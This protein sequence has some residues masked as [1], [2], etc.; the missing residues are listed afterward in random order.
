MNWR[1]EL[2]TIL[3]SD[4]KNP[5][6]FRMLKS[7]I[8]VYGAGS[9]GN[10]ALDFMRTINIK[11]KYIVDKIFQGELH[12]IKVIKP[13]EI[14]KSD[15]DELTFIICIATVS[16]NPIFNYLKTMG[17]KDVRHFYDYSEIMFPG[18]MPN[19]WVAQKIKKEDIDGINQTFKALEHDKC[20]IAHYLQF[21]WW[22][23]KRKE[24]INTDYPV[25]S[26]KKFFNAPHFPK[27]NSQ[28][29]FVDAGVHFGQTIMSFVK[30]TD[31]QF[32]YICGFEPDL[33]NQRI[34]KKNISSDIMEKTTLFDEAL[35]NEVQDLKFEDGLGFASK[36]SKKGKKTV[37][38]TALDLMSQIEPTII[39]LHIEGGELKALQGAK[40]KIKKYRPI[41]MIMAD[42]SIDGLYKITQA[43]QEQKDYILYFNLHD[44][45]GNSA[46]IYGYPKERLRK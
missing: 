6:P 20:S 31:M 16:V 40:K 1:S 22:R 42:H 36:I 3:K 33:L 2:N 21:L 26:G 44:Y 13:F 19:G 25:L 10:M 11:P 7:D 34:L 43:L 23:L 46:V 17:C 29:I 24:V 45:C 8:V 14:P 35:F 32:K 39:K 4:F 18:K 28:E 12:G 30:K 9:M 27:L 41:M 15:L 37:K 38:T 5:N